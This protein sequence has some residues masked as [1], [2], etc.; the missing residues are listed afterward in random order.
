MGAAVEY[1]YAYPFNSSLDTVSTGAHLRLATF[2]GQ[3]ASPYFFQ[4]KLIHPR[5]TADLLLALS[6]VSRTRFYMP[7][8]MIARIIAA[9][10]PV[11]TSGG[12]LLRYEAFSLCCGVYARLDLL[13]QAVDGEF[14]G[15]GTTNVDFNPPMRAALARLHS[16]DMVGISV[17][18]DRFELTKGDKKVVERKVT[19]PVRWLKGFVE[20]QSYQSRMTK[21]L[22]VSRDEALRFLRTV[23]KQN[24]HYATSWV[25]P[26]GKGLRITQRADNGAVPVGGIGR[27]KILEDLL[28]QAKSLRIYAADDDAVSG[29]ELVFDDARFHLVLSPE[30]ARGFSGEGQVLS[31]LA[32]DRWKDALPK[33]RASLQWQA[34][35]EKTDLARRLKLDEGTVST[36]LSALGSRGLVGYDVAEQAYFHRELPF[37]FSLVD[38]LQPRLK[39]ARALVEE[40][41]VRFISKSDETL[42]AYVRGTDVEH[43]VRRADGELRCTCPWFSKNQ[44]QRGPCK[45]IL[46]VQ[47][48]LGNDD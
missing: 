36:A 4:G 8:N 38:D 27:I 3:E 34:K 10:D 23:P 13:P 48:E 18:T 9:A 42:E 20:V 19:L 46:A 43:R 28:R 25:V 6:L 17:G 11:I 15:R 45:H 35:I 2:G 16:N 29:W 24:T 26:L 12:D 32:Q 40:K 31:Q 47:I 30:S 14:V 33:V 41:G 1:A 39:E 5:S 44:G 37:D 7:P 21:R 22:E